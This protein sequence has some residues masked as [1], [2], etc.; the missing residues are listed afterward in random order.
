MW[1]KELT[2]FTEQD[3]THVKLMLQLD[4]NSLRS[5]ANGKAYKFGQLTTPTLAQLSAD[6]ELI[7][8][9]SN[10]LTSAICVQEVIADVQDLHVNPANA[11]AL[12]QV[13]SQF[14][15]LEMTG[16]TV[17]PES[18][19]TGYYSDKTQGPACAIAC[20]AGLIYRNYFVPLDG[21]HGQTA[22]RQLN[23]LDHFETA[24]LEQVNAVTGQNFTSLWLMKN[25]YAL[26]SEK[27]LI[28][29]NTTL[30][31]LTTT[32]QSLLLN[33]IKIG[34]QYNSDVTIKNAQ[35]AVS[36]A[37]CSAMPVAY[38]SSQ[39]PVLW[40]PLA[41]LILQAAYQATLAAAVINASKTGKKT[42]YLTLLGGGVFG[43]KIDWI[44]KAIAQALDKYKN[45]GLRV[46]IVS[47]AR[48]KPEVIKLI[49]TI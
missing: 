40:Q 35:H 29:I 27:Q 14:N 41:S 26:P 38:S 11:G 1:F 33:T 23:M 25:G 20:G 13:A 17:T 32:E 28:A 24:L 12:F 39:N 43:N 48:S 45:S 34:V 44:I 46:N 21:E 47:F 4:G 31:T 7:I 42:V 15:L 9:Q 5:Q 22:N 37:Y 18:G 19:V 6:A 2:G 16:P 36:Q 10:K 8:A 49:T 30:S 3:A